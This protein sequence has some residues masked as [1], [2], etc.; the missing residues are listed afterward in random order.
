MED[1]TKYEQSGKGSPKRLNTSPNLLLCTSTYQHMLF[2]VTIPM[3]T[4]G[5]IQEFYKEEV[6]I[7]TPI[8]WVWLLKLNMMT[9]N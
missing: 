6:L 4:Q 1:Y 5:Q 9:L 7:A 8:R 3:Y 2:M